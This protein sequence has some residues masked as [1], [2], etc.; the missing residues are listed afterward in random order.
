MNNGDGQNNPNVPV[1][2]LSLTGPNPVVNHEK[3]AND[4]Q[5]L[6]DLKS[7]LAAYE[8]RLTAGYA[9]FRDLEERQRLEETVRQ[10]QLAAQLLAEMRGGREAGAAPTP[11]SAGPSNA[12]QQSVFTPVFPAQGGASYS[13]VPSS[14]Q[15]VEVPPSQESPQPVLKPKLPRVNLK[16]PKLPEAGLE[17]P[18]L[19]QVDLE[20]LLL[21]TT[22]RKAIRTRPG[23]SRTG[24]RLEPRPPSCMVSSRHQKHMTPEC[25]YRLRLWHRLPLDQR[26]NHIMQAHNSQIGHINGS[27]SRLAHRTLL[28]LPLPRYPIPEAQILIQQT[29]RAIRRKQTGREKTAAE[30]EVES[31]LKASLVKN[32][33]LI[34]DHLKGYP[35]SEIKDV[36]KKY[37]ILASR[38]QQAAARPDGSKASN[39]APQHPQQPAP[40]V[41]TSTSQSAPPPQP[42]GASA[43][44]PATIQ[45]PVLQPTITPSSSATPVVA[46]PG[47][48]TAVP[49]ATTSTIAASSTSNANPVGA[50]FTQI[51]WYT[52]RD[53]TAPIMVRNAQGQIQWVHR[54]MLPQSAAP[55]PSAQPQVPS[56]PPASKAA[57]RPELSATPQPRPASGTA[58]WTPEKADRSRLA[59][60]IM[61]SLGRPKGAFGAPLSPTDTISALRFEVIHPP[62]V[63]STPT[64]TPTATAAAKRKASLARSSPVSPTAVKRPRLD[65]QQDEQDLVVAA[66]TGALSEAAVVEGVVPSVSSEHE[67][68]PPAAVAA[69]ERAVKRETEEA[70][71]MDHV[72]AATLPLVDGDVDVPGHDLLVPGLHDADTVR[73][74][75]ITS[76][77]A[78]N[79]DRVL[80]VTTSEPEPEPI[81]DGVPSR[82]AR[83]GSESSA[84]FAPPVYVERGGQG[85]HGALHATSSPLQ[86][87]SAAASNAT[88]P[89]SS[90]VASLRDKGKGKEKV[91]LFLPSPSGSPEPYVPDDDAPSDVSIA[92]RL[93]GGRKGKGRALDADLELQ[94]LVDEDG[95]SEVSSAA[96]RK[97]RRTNRAYVLAPPLPAY[98]A[99]LRGNEIV[100]WGSQSPSSSVASGSRY[101]TP[102]VGGSASASKRASPAGED[103][104]EDELPEW[105][106]RLLFPDEGVCDENVDQGPCVA[107]DEEVGPVAELEPDADGEEA[108][109]A[110][111]L[112]FSRLREMPCSWDGCGAVLNSMATLQKHVVRHAGE[113][114]EWGTFTCQWKGCLSN[115]FKDEQSLVRHLQK[116]ARSPLLCAYEGCDRSFASASDLLHHHQS[117]KHRDGQLRKS[118]YPAPPPENRRQLSPLP[119][120]LPVYMF[121]VR[122]VRRHPISRDRHQWVGPKVLENI[123]SFKYTGRRSH[124]GQPSRLSRRLAEK[125]VA[126]ELASVTPESGHA[127]IRRWIDDEYLDFADG[128]DASRRYRVWC[129]D[130]PAGEVTQMVHDGL[131]L[132][133]DGDG[134]AGVYGGTGG[135]EGGGEVDRSAD[136]GGGGGQERD[137]DAEDGRGA[138]EDAAPAAEEEGSKELSPPPRSGEGSP[139]RTNAEGQKP[140]IRLKLTLP[141]RSNVIRLPARPSQTEAVPHRDGDGDADAVAGNSNSNTSALPNPGRIDGSKTPPPAALA[142]QSPVRPTPTSTPQLPE[143]A[144]LAPSPQHL[145]SVPDPSTD[146]VLGSAWTVWPSAKEESVETH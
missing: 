83:A 27:T 108:E 92:P 97:R 32:A 132:F 42:N 47:P 26:H 80:N 34:A 12:T 69:P 50:P 55:P 5:R 33:D 14:A 52:P 48:F 133:V 135:E 73:G 66:A 114:S 82:E 101:G 140:T 139:G 68:E 17:S 57:P 95:A 61:R 1:N 15:I 87:F 78:A 144:V 134:D 60:D 110:A 88:P 37:L 53:P 79:I 138:G 142:T 18:K 45:L 44:P 16:F 70:E 20:F 124:A 94:Q 28:E 3:Y 96:P 25:K 136:G 64:P 56:T 126:V 93:P 59:Q 74:V 90:P 23:H 102:S 67:V 118:C 143:P 75:S 72:D 29:L 85:P 119:D 71:D 113:N 105:R 103:G 121:T 128:Y 36:F 81:T 84:D 129:A 2:G 13:E 137:L 116:H 7:Y 130:I 112:A 31:T 104:M 127:Q 98:A 38:Q 21:H 49:T 115:S 107:A 89:P 41:L 30:A 77:E 58:A 122:P 4:M 111:E 117:S 65:G 54:Q 40:S 24:Q 35:E 109:A 86:E 10:G 141:R 120:V 123:T 9:K 91:P 106:G 43:Q 51:S 62:T 131:A 99:S 146:E 100:W 76:S 46:A 11:A 22:P 145:V 125:V 63:T 19:P 39:A 6:Q 8:E